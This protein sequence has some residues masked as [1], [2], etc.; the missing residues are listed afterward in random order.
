MSALDRRTMVF[1]GSD[2]DD[3]PEAID[4]IEARVELVSAEPKR[5]PVGETRE[6]VGDAIRGPKGR[7]WEIECE[8]WGFTTLAGN[9]TSDLQDYGEYLRLDEV[10]RRRFLYVYRFYQTGANENFGPAR[11]AGEHGYDENGADVFWYA[12]STTLDGYPSS[13]AGHLPMAVECPSGLAIQK[14][15]GGVNELTFTLVSRNII[16]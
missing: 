7:R 11:R 15:D 8:A 14:T 5:V 9:T 13:A 1:R 6:Y 2:T 4:A 10:M 3:D 12:R 16:T